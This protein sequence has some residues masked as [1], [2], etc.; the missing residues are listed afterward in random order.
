MKP[1]CQGAKTPGHFTSFDCV[2]DAG[3]D[4]FCQPYVAP[5]VD[6]WRARMEWEDEVVVSLE[7][8]QVLVHRID[9]ARVSFRQE[10]LELRASAAEDVKLIQALRGENTRLQAELDALRAILESGAGSTKSASDLLANVMRGD[11]AW[12]TGVAWAVREAHRRLTGGPPDGVYVR[13]DDESGK[14][15]P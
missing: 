12:P 5:S 7:R 11:Y 6:E 9:A 3:H 10:C 14:A 8:I 2:L 1:R 15:S 13:A 4:G